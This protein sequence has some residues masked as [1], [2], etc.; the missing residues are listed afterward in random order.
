MSF[1][2]VLFCLSAGALLAGCAQG[3]VGGLKDK[4]AA[5]PESTPVTR[6]EAILA[7]LPPAS[8]KV[9]VAVY[10]FPD[11]TGQQKPSELFAEFSK[12]V[13]QGNEALL[14]DSLLDAG[15]GRWFNV[16]ERTGLQNLVTE[17]NLINQT[18]TEYK[19]TTVS[20]LPPLRYAGIIIE[21]G[22]INYDSNVT[23]GGAGARL[24][25]IGANVDY[26]RD[27]ITVALRAVSV[28]TGQVLL[29]VQ[30]EKTVYS[31][32]QQA[33]V[34]RY[35]STDE[36]LEL[37]AGVTRNEP[38]GLAVRQAIELAVFSMIVEGAEKNI[39]SF[40]N[41]SAQSAIIQKY[42]TRKAIEAGSPQAIAAEQ[43]QNEAEAAAKAAAAAG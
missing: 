33:S 43:A 30:T 26:R 15:D 14:I 36:I 11:Q 37:E 32:L 17:R 38:V 16:V 4:L 27:R 25:G 31:F 28:A 18:N 34:F 29:S 19:N 40:S 23:T 3:F 5:E 1:R 8:R 6:S 10:S 21:G 2:R 39:W 12:A 42:N 35:V 13:T 7:T 9:D 24:L 22:V 41:K 20:E